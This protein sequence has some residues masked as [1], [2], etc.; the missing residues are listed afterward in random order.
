[1]ENA[2]LACRYFNIGHLYA[3]K[4]NKYELTWLERGITYYIHVAAVNASAATQSYVAS[5]MQ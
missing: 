3:T 2:S 4:D 5:T 1:L